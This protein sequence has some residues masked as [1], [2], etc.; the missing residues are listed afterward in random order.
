MMW[1]ECLVVYLT[2]LILPAVIVASCQETGEVASCQERENRPRAN[3]QKS[4]A[5]Q[6]P[7]A[8][9]SVE[10]PYLDVHESYMPDDDG[11]T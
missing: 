9:G 8:A 7:S 11:V 10:V 5:E 3:K 2:Y 1:L 4:A 6:V